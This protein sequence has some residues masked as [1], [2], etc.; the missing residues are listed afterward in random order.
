MVSRGKA[1]CR[2]VIDLPPPY[3]QQSVYAARVATAMRIPLIVL[4]VW[5]PEAPRCARAPHR[6][7]LV[8]KH[9]P[10]GTKIA[11]RNVTAI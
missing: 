10:I 11:F 8:R 3:R 4:R 9:L 5:T 6:S 2:P 1:R 7:T